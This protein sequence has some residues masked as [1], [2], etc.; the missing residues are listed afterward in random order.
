MS[1]RQRKHEV[2]S[3]CFICGEFVKLHMLHS[4]LD[5]FKDEVGAYSEEQGERFHQDVEELPSIKIWAMANIIF[6]NDDMAVRQAEL[7]TLT[8]TSVDEICV[9]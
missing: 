4:H 8:V 6:R 3:F 7:A 9:A 2:D 5:E 1:S